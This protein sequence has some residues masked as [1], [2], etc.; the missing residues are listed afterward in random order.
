M[1]RIPILAALLLLALAPGYAQFQAGDIFLN[2]DVGIAVSGETK[3]ESNLSSRPGET[4]SRR[5]NLNFAPSLGY[6]LSDKLAIGLTL[7][8]RYLRN[9]IEVTYNDASEPAQDAQQLSNAFSPQVF[10]RYNCPLGDRLGFMFDLYAGPSFGK[11]KFRR[12]GT[13]LADER[14]SL[15]FDAGLRPGGYY[16]LS[17]KLALEVSFGGLEYSA[18]RFEADGQ[19]AGPI[20]ERSLSTL[21]SG[22]NLSLRL[23]LNYFLTRV[24]PASKSLK[25]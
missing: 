25:I 15:G 19:S 14:T 23:G 22:D 6:L 1:K 12:L 4:V 18:K 20:K 7:D 2:G 10:L 11:E 5:L 17:S 9:N 8:F 24:E 3:N 13:V 21:L 16:F